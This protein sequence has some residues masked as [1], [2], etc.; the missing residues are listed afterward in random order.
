[1]ILEVFSDDLIKSDISEN[2]TRS[3]RAI[4]K[5]NQSI[6]VLYSKKLDFY[7][8][9]GGRIEQGETPEDC[10]VREV[11]EETGFKVNLLKATVI[12]KEYFLDSTWES[13]FFLCE[14]S[15]EKKASLTLT[16]EEQSLDLETLWLTQVEALNL[17]D[18]YDSN[19]NKAA[20]IM[21][22]EFLALINSL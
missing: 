7:M 1:M 5:K 8:L 15:D 2:L 16:E 17:F 14:L 18:S 20:N 4:V 21:Q 9:P 13:H 3:S 22:R 19:F 10:L 11:K 12:I 6:L